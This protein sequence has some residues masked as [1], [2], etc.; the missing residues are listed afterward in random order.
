M[1]SFLAVGTIDRYFC[2]EIGEDRK[3]LSFAVNSD[4]QLVLREKE[5]GNAE[6][7]LSLKYYPLLYRKLPINKANK[8][9]LMTIKGIGPALSDSIIE[10]RDKIGGFRS[11]ENFQNVPKL[12]KD[13]AL[14]FSSEII[15]D[16][17][18]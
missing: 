1:F 14:Q 16:E 13:R 3:K 17:Q 18:E 4:Q 6:D 9:L 11:I 2:F 8:E 7:V 5:P 12:G 10:Y 15:F